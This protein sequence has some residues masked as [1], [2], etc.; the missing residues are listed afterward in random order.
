MARNRSRGFAGAT[1]DFFPTPA[2]T[3]PSPLTVSPGDPV[4]MVSVVIRADAEPRGGLVPRLIRYGLQI[5]A[6][7]GYVTLTSLRA[8][9]YLFS[10]DLADPERR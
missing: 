9:G 1:I 2:S 4:T 3:D 7:M 8:V 10:P 6:R 5:G